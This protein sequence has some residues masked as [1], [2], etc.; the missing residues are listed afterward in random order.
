VASAGSK[1]KSKKD[2]SGL[3]GRREKM[4]KVES[5]AILRELSDRV[6][7]VFVWFR[8]CRIFPRSKENQP[9]E[10]ILPQAAIAGCRL[11]FATSGLCHHTKLD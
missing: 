10:G 11:K 6:F 8:A 2:E 4:E 9:I 3:K 7:F 5:V 1:K